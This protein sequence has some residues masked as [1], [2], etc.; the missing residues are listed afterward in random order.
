MMIFF[1][2]A[3]LSSFYIKFKSKKSYNLFLNPLTII[4]ILVF[5]IVIGLRYNVGI[6]YLG[7]KKQYDIF[8]N[9]NVRD[10]DIYFEFA[11]LWLFKVLA[12]LK[13]SYVWPFI[14][15][16]F[17]QIYCIYLQSR[18]NLFL[19]PY[20]IFFYFV[21]TNF[22][23]SLNIMRQI[24]AL[25][26]LFFGTKFILDKKIISWIT[27]CFLASLFHITAFVGLL[28]YFFNKDIFKS[29]Y[30]SIL[31][32]PL[33]YFLGQFVFKNNLNLLLDKFLP[34]VMPEYNSDSLL[35]Q[36]RGYVIRNHFSF[37]DMFITISNI[38]FIYNYQRCS[39]VYQKYGFILYFNLSIL[40]TLLFPIVADNILLDRINYY[41]YG[42][43]FI[44]FSFYAHYFLKI[45]KRIFEK[46]III[47]FIILMFMQF[48][49]SIESRNNGISPFQFVT[50]F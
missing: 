22:M 5:T 3:E 27:C 39:K 7:Y 42:F 48:I 13:F 18:R 43:R 47:G 45:Q 33:I 36:D 50:K 24:I 38:F 26:I 8:L 32:I 16:A 11:Y 30:L 46:L 44:T 1:S 12:F 28:F 2:S 9:P 20:I 14:V 40:G 17:I 29:K 25:N 15:T 6:D 21:S 37:F 4:P 10:I 23:Y 31:L 19:L 34:Y 41:F 35:S 49:I